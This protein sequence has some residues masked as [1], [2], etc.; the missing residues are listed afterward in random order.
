MAIWT[1]GRVFDHATNIAFNPGGDKVPTIGEDL[2]LECSQRRGKAR[3]KRKP[4]MYQSIPPEPSLLLNRLMCSWNEDR[5][6]LDKVLGHQH[7][8][9][10]ERQRTSEHED[11]D[12]QA[13]TTK[14][15][16][17]RKTPANDEP[18]AAHEH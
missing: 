5:T 11:G 16:A 3:G 14:P 8:F 17:E 15:P 10:G 18:E 2:H 9:V 13:T 1:L 4:R 6:E 7:F 12:A